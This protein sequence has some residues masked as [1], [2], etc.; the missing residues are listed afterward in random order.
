MKRTLIRTALTT[1]GLSSLL[2]AVAC[3]QGPVD[4]KDFDESQ[5]PVAE[6]AVT[7]EKAAP[8]R[9]GFHDPAKM[10]EKLDRNKDGILQLS[11]VPER[12]ARFLGE[13]DTDKDGTLSVTE[14]EAHQVAMKAKR[15][16]RIDSDKDGFVTEAEVGRRWDKLKVADADND[17]KLTQ[18][19]LEQ[20]HANGKLPALGRHGKRGFR[21]MHQ[22]MGRDMWFEQ[23]DAN[24]NGSLEL[25]EVPEKKRAFLEKADKDGNQV[26]S[27]DELKAH[28]EAK[29]AQHMGCDKD[30]AI[31]EGV[32]PTL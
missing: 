17:G 8:A 11:E 21:G 24:K 29:R 22:R 30:V 32:S 15:F 13:A 28:F 18:A 26:L 19:E 9:K 31:D 23:L 2:A 1:F 5:E 6:Q 16:A 20:A 12:K 4:T 7:P 3:S 14:L 27:K 25:S 10:I